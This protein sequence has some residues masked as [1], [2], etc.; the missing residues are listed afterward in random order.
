M[1]LQQAIGR[2]DRSQ[3]HATAYVSLYAPAGRRR[4][5]MYLYRCPT[6][7]TYQLGRARQ[8]DDVTG[9]RRAGCRHEVSIVVARV[10]GNPEAGT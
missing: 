5:W 8:L 3:R 1:T 6:C 4:L 9:M 2:V 7:G 10:Y